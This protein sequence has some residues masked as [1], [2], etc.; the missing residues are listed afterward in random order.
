M[1]AVEVVLQNFTE[2]NKLWVRMQHQVS[3]FASEM[4]TSA[5]LTSSQCPPGLV[6][7]KSGLCCSS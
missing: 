6:G 1:D 5:G 7:K 4:K 3:F 2:M